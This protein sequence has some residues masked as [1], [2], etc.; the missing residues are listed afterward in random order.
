VYVSLDDPYLKI[1]IEFPK[2]IFDLTKHA[3]YITLAGSIGIWP[4]DWPNI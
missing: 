3:N 4:T 1:T 2:T